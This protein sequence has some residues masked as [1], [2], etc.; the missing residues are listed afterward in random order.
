MIKLW[1]ILFCV[2]CLHNDED[3]ISWNETY[4]LSWSDFKGEPN[5]ETD[6]V[7]T[8][9][10]GITFSYALKK[11]GSQIISF[12]SLVKAHFYPEKS[13]YK[14][15][16]TDAHILSHEQHHFNITELH[17]RKFRQKIT[18]LEPSINLK[19]DLEKLHEEANIDLSNMQQRY[20][21]ETDYSRNFEQQQI[22]QE[23]IQFELDKL[24]EFQSKN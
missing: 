1:F 16:Q 14:S 7:A 4:K 24:A 17:T 2:L 10:S 5:I 15:E 19:S 13:W 23:H 8:T 12:K 9:A 20:D 18:I 6:A 11:T 21:E 3:V 22:W